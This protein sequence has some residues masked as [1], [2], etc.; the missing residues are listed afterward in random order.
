MADQTDVE[1]AIVGLLAGVI[2]PN[3]ISQPPG[4]GVVAQIFPGWPTPAKIDTLMA[5]GTA[6]VWVYARPEVKEK[7][8]Y[9]ME[10]QAPVIVPPT[11]TANVN[12]NTVTIGGA[13]P[14][15][16]SPH[17][18]FVLLAGQAFG[19]ALQQSDTPTSIATALANLI[20]AAF[21]GTANAGPVITVASG[22]ILTARVGTVGTTVME[23]GRFEQA[24]QI[25]VAAN[26]P[27]LRT[28]LAAAI[29]PVLMVTDF[30][31]MPDGMAARLITRAPVDVD[32]AQKVQIYRR[33]FRVTVEYAVTMTQTTAT[34]EAVNVSFPGLNIPTR[35]F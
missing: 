31:T 30:F 7:T 28:A 2:Y 14:S 23:V 20:G 5:S 13:M 21:P 32:T 8:N 16:F 15:P 6:C 10:W 3:G 26:T 25:V 9:P 11:L 22:A 1:N 27:A 24:F 18:I 4:Q 33:D 19:Y 12:G 34:V 29:L 35:S 17:N